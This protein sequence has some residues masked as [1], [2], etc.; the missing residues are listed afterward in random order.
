MND[1]TRSLSPIHCTYMSSRWDLVLHVLK[2]KQDKLSALSLHP[3]TQTGCWTEAPELLTSVVF[4]DSVLS[5]AFKP[6][7]ERPPSL[8]LLKRCQLNEQIGLWQT[9]RRV[10]MWGFAKTN[11]WRGCSFS[12]TTRVNCLH[13]CVLWDLWGSWRFFYQT[14]T[15]KAENWHWNVNFRN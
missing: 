13:R 4:L 6:V 3:V 9:V 11:Y 7:L 12:R 14:G 5:D 15:L 10:I 2:T 8:L 1:T